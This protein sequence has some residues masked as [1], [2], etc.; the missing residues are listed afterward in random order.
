M[1][2]LLRQQP[3]HTVSMKPMPVRLAATLALVLSAAQAASA[4]TVFSNLGESTLLGEGPSNTSLRMATDF[5]TDASASTITGAT[6]SMLS[7]NTSFANTYTVSLFA[8]NGA[9]APG[10]LVGTFDPFT[11]P[12]NTS[13]LSNHTAVSTGI[14]LAANTAYW[15]VLQLNH[16]GSGNL[17]GW[18][19]TTSQATDAG[20]VFTTIPATSVMWSFDAGASYGSH[21]DGNYQFSLESSAV[22][23]PSRALLLLGGLACAF[24][25]RRRPAT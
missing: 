5:L 4:A 2:N 7:A 11:V 15:V 20:S 13:G 24:L 8:D 17:S 18:A 22:P 21:T 16:A 12:A 19:L 10:A 9:D 6:L 1:Q 23:E 3:T 14:N 25:R